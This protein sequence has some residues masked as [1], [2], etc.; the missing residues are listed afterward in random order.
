MTEP[1]QYISLPPSS[2]TEGSY[3]VRHNT[4]NCVPSIE[5]IGSENVSV[6][7]CPSGELLLDQVTQPDLKN[8]V[9][10]RDIRSFLKWSKSTIPLKQAFLTMQFSNETMVTRVV[11]YCLVL[12]DLK[13]REPKKFRLFS[14]TTESFYPMTEINNVD[15]SV[16]TV[17]S[18]GSTTLQRTNN[19]DN[20]NDDDDDIIYSKYEYRKYNLEIPEDRQIPL[21]SLRISMDFEGDNWIF[22]SEVELYHTEILHGE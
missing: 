14:S 20:D 17:T 6:I 4:E 3:N 15:S 19:G 11:V 16:F 9:T 12:Q 1:A 21:K 18:T 7:T 5:V 13:I 2:F 8:I 10:S 22:I